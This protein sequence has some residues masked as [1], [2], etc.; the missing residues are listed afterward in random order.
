[1]TEESG[2][3]PYSILGV[4]RTASADEIKKA[5]RKFARKFHPDVNPGDKAA[6]ERFKEVSAAFET[7][8]DPDKRKLYDEFGDE[9]S[10]PGFDPEKAR[11]YREWQR[12]AEAT[13]AYR[14]GSDDAFSGRGG[15]D[16][17][18]IF[19]DFSG[20]RSDPRR[21]ADVE[22]EIEIT[23][24]EAVLGSEREVAFTR[25]SACTDCDGRGTKATGK[26]DACS[27]CGGSGRV[28]VSRGPIAF[29]R[30]CGTCAGSGQRP[31][32]PCPRCG[33]TGRVER[34]VRLNVRVPAGVDDGQNIR[35]AG[36][37][38]PGSRGGPGGDLFLRVRVRA[39][40]RLERDGRNLALRVPVTVREAML[41]AKIEV[42][43]LQG[44]IK[45]SVPAGSQT[46]T[47]LR[48]RGRGVPAAGNSPA[49]DL[50]VILEVQV[51]LAPADADAAARAA[52]AIDELYAGD[53]RAELV[54]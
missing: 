18:D 41:G 16:L 35:L 25:P 54:V 22:T 5:Y 48:V 17:G 51:P 8:G 14:G 19:G 45:L 31:G 27:E 24:R 53:V 4:A 21:G 23:L 52:A 11:A 3:D 6:E 33:G 2:K 26:A 37:G 39:H 32:P 34:K 7:I 43:T 42:P 12:R 47:R 49:G 46:G 30:V 28:G 36:Q 38:M 1:M 15:F 9:G 20:G 10:R 50:F 44:P 13:S 40:P 29:Q